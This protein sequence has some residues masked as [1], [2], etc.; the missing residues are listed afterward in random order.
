MPN[1][2]VQQ[3]GTRWAAVD[4]RRNPRAAAQLPA[5]V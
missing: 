4:L 2:L 3:P 1:Q 5:A